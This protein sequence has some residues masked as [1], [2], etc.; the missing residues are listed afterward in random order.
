MPKKYDILYL[1][2]AERDLTD[3]FEYIY[4]DNPYVAASFLNTIDNT[5][6]K[7]ADFPEM[8]TVPNDSRLKNLGYRMLIIEEYIVFYVIKEKI[9]EIR[10][11]LHGKRKY[12]FLL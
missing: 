1:S 4:K 3:I 9:V 12:E 10:R 7:L 8:G 5:I 11:I 2:I 6:A